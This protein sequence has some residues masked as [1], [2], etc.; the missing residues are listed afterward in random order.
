MEMLKDFLEGREVYVDCGNGLQKILVDD[1]FRIREECLVYASLIR[2]A[3]ATPAIAVEA[4]GDVDDYIIL[5]VA[6][7]LAKA[8]KILK[9]S[10][11]YIVFHC[12]GAE[13]LIN[14]DSLPEEI[15][16]QHSSPLEAAKI[17]SNYMLEVLE[18]KL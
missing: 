1:V 18:N 14:E 12:K 15:F 5:S 11:T 16:R 4:E 13:I 7:Y 9:F 10:S 17:V 2:R 8:L 6:S 3:K